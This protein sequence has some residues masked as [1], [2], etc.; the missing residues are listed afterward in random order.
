MSSDQYEIQLFGTGIGEYNLTVLTFE[1][2]NSNLQTVTG[3]VIK[4]TVHKYTMSISND[5]IVDIS[6]N[7]E[8]ED[9]ELP[10]WQENWYVIIVMLALAFCGGGYGIRKLRLNRAERLEKQRLARV[11][12]RVS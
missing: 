6:L 12:L 7:E 2:T 5:K 11:V 9:I 1:E 3:H 10:W 4:N 8:K